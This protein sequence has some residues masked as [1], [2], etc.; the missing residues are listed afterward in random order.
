[1][2]EQWKE[3]GLLH[4]RKKRLLLHNSACITDRKSWSLYK[5]DKLCYGDFPQ[6]RKQ[7][8]NTGLLKITFLNTKAQHI[9]RH[10]FDKLGS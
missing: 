1:M 7:P 3:E 5:K 8:V 4:L 10:W 2:E 6:T 9:P